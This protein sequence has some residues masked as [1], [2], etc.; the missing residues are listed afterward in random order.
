MSELADLIAR[1][2]TLEQQYRDNGE[3][4]RDGDDY[5]CDVWDTAADDLKMLIREFEVPKP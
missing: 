3:L 1:L 5:T 2:K 4:A